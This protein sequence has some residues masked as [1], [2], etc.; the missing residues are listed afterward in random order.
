MLEVEHIGSTAVPGMA[1][2]P[3]IDIMA[4]VK[5]MAV[6]ESLLVPLRDF[7][8]V[9][10]TD[11]NEGLLDRRWL[12][13]QTGG[14]RTHHLHLVVLGGEGWCRTVKFRDLLRNHPN[15]AKR[16]ES[17]KTQLLEITEADRTKYAQAKTI[18]IEELLQEYGQSH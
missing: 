3:I 6:A 2:K 4:G 1:S 7:G 9:T 16:Y 5:S 18:I 8:Y 12:M 13:R 11:C 17:M 14:Q 15:A 10:P